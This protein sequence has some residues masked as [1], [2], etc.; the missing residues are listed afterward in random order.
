MR[1]IPKATAIE[2]TQNERTVLEDFV[3]ST[4]TEYRLR[5]RARIVLLAAGGMATS[6]IG[7]ED[8]CTTGTASKWRVTKCDSVDN[9]TG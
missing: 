7:R 3:R 2:L 6:A 9:A 4:R 5:Q 8:G 1:N